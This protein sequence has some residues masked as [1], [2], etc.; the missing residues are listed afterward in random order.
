[1]GDIFERQFLKQIYSTQKILENAIEDML[2]NIFNL[3]D[4]DGDG[5]LD[6]EDFVSFIS[7]LMYISLQMNRITDSEYNL[8]NVM[9]FTA[10]S[11]SNFLSNLFR[12]PQEQISYDKFLDGI[13]NAVTENKV[14]PL[15]SNRF[16]FVSFI[17]EII[18]YFHYYDKLAIRRNWPVPQDDL[19]DDEVVAEPLAIEHPIVEPLAIEQPI[20]EQPIVE[21]PVVDPSFILT[22][23]QQ[24]LDYQQRR[25]QQYE[26]HRLQQLQSQQPLPALLPDSNNDDNVRPPIPSYTERLIEQD[27]EPEQL[28]LNHT[29][30]PLECAGNV[31]IDIEQE[32]FEPIDGNVNVLEF[33][34]ENIEDNVAFKLG[35]S[36]FLGRRSR[37]RSM[38]NIGESQNSIFYACSCELDVDWTRP[39][40]WAL[41]PRV[42]IQNPK[43][44]NIQHIGLPIRYIFLND[45]ITLLQSKDNYFLIEALEEFP[46]IPSFASDTVL[47]HG[48][49]SMSGIHCQ[50]GQMDVVYRLKTLTF[51]E[52]APVILE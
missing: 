22:Q 11:S 50:S 47:N 43:F 8:E 49:G 15:S 36:Y 46:V 2:R 21:P 5:Q 20:V 44:F 31:M 14:F 41:L 9:Q 29:F 17:P 13:L 40:P 4:S 28:P 19:N 18:N 51:C 33:I 37:I 24:I 48:I 38:I 27:Y 34:H 30:P 12:E 10:W 42:I 3:Y 6:S 32:G 7:D 52:S 39:E 1:M 23:E 35:E 26:L 25:Q 45:I 16:Y